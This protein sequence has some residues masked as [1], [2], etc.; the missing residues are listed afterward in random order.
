MKN[1]FSSMNF[2]CWLEAVNGNKFST[3]KTHTLSQATLE[4]RLWKSYVAS[5]NS[6]ENVKDLTRNS[7]QQ[8]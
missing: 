6:V 7:T 2:R 1:W 3:K 4:V 8:L 5:F